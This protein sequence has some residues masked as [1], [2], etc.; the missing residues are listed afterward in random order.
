MLT[1]QVK[2][3]G[4]NIP[5]IGGLDF[6]PPFASM[7]NDPAIA[8]N[9]YFANNYSDTE[10]QLKEINEAYKAKYNES[11]INKAFLGYD[12]V[13]V[14]AEALKKAGKGDA[15]ALKSALEKVKDVKGSTG[16]ITLS[17]K[18]HSPVGL[19]MVMYQIEKGQYKDLGRYIPEEHKQ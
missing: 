16:V 10:P 6:A 3:L 12:K 4:I 2:Q 15:E 14:V 5:L 18:T 1:K 9:I 17:E 8:D 13:L 11:P 7:V 19:S